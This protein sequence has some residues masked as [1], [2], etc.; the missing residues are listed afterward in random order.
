MKYL[1][2]YGWFNSGFVNDLGKRV[3]GFRPAMLV[4]FVKHHKTP[5]SIFWLGQ[6]M[7]DYEDSLETWGP[8]RTHLTALVVSTLNGC[9]FCTR[10]HI[11]AFQLHHLKLND[12]LFPLDDKEFLRL[13]KLSPDEMIERLAAILI[14]AGLSDQV[15]PLRRTFELY[16]QPERADNADDARLVRM[17]DLFATQDLDGRAADTMIDQVHD[18]INRDQALQLRYDGLR[19]T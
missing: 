18:P 15:Q 17:I 11:R 16:V 4:H 1:S 10:G 2:A 5:H 19:T 6:R 8:L 7:R 13:T 9:G 12:R 3:L 14:D